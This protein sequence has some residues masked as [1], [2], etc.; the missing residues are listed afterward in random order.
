MLWDELYSEGYCTK[1]PEGIAVNNDSYYFESVAGQQADDASILNYYKKAM[2]LRNLYPEIARGKVE[3]LNGLSG[4]TTGD[5][6]SVTRRT[7]NGS[8]VIVVM[9]LNMQEEETVYLDK[10]VLG[11]GDKMSRLLA[12]PNYSIVKGSK[13][14]EF[15]MSP[16]SILVLK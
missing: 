8:N 6:V 2:K 16:Y 13:E 15:T 9:N 12:N 7:W 3:V 11:Y 5:Q 10:A 1:S 4:V 14:G